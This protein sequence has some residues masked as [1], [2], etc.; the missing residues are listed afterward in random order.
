MDPRMPRSEKGASSVEYGLLIVA[1]AA[2]LA[3]AVFALGGVTDEMF[4]D[5][6]DEFDAQASVSTTC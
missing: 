4:G 3:I 2:V 5:T 1:I 6:C